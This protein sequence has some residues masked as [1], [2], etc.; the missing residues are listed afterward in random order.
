LH[1]AIGH[2]DDARGDAIGA[3]A[4]DDPAIATLPEQAAEP[5]R[6]AHEDQ[7]VEL[8]EVPFV[9]QEAVE[10]S[11]RRPAGPA[12]PACGCTSNRRAKPSTIITNGDHTTQL[13]T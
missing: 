13:G 2:I 4:I 8:V 5:L 6:R 12:D 7:V 9:E 10:K 3:D 1:D 11:C